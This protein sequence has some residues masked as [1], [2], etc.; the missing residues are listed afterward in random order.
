MFLAA[1][2]CIPPGTVCCNCVPTIFR[3]KNVALRLVDSLTVKEEI[4]LD[5]EMLE[6]GSNAEPEYRTL[7]DGFF[8]LNQLCILVGAVWLMLFWKILA[9]IRDEPLSAWSISGTVSNPKTEKQQ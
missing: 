5:E 1:H 6:A 4:P 9:S 7:T 2:T 3:P 8:P